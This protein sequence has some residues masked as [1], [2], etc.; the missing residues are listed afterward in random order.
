MAPKKV[1]ERFTGTITVTLP[2]GFSISNP[3]DWPLDN[4]PTAE[5]QQSAYV[6]AVIATHEKMERT[7]PNPGRKGAQT[8]R[9]KGAER[10]QQIVDAWK[11]GD[12]NT[13]Q[14]WRSRK[15]LAHAL[16]VHPKTVSRALESP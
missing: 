7:N 10:Y 12:P 9:S 2:D 1:P 11:H 4:A 8:N 15:A 16:K 13:G 6:A 14:P 5:A 3:K